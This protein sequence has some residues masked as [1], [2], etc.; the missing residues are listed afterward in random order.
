VKP[1]VGAKNILLAVGF[2]IP[3]EGNDRS[4]LILKEDA[5]FELLKSTKIKL[6]QALVKYG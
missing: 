3:R 4:H 6:E 2:A 5:D 1:F